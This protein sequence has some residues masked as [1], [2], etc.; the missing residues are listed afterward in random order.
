MGIEEGKV[1]SD[2]RQSGKLYHL[3]IET[4]ATNL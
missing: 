2:F 4:I 1:S 3:L